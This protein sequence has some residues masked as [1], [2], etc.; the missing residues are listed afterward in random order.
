MNLN[1]SIKNKS[2]SD[3]RV[4]SSIEEA[5]SIWIQR[6]E[7]QPHNIGILKHFKNSN[8]YTISPNWGKFFIYPALKEDLEESYY[9]N[10]KCILELFNYIRENI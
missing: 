4:Y 10:R 1:S 9:A 8:I 7:P 3:I 6:F 2:S 5:A